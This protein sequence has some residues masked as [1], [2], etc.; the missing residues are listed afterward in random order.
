VRKKKRGEEEE[1]GRGRRKG[2]RKKKGRE[3]KEKGRGRRKGESVIRVMP[4]SRL[5]RS[6]DG[7]LQNAIVATVNSTDIAIP[8]EEAMGNASG[9]PFRERKAA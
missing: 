9:E 7:P 5:T 6:Y 4:D 2:E 8:S 1:R 3:E